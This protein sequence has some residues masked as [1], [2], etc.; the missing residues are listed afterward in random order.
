M[1]G[2]SDGAT[3]EEFGR[4]VLETVNRKDLEEV[5]TKAKGN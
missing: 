3:G 1:T 2:R 5:W 4:Y